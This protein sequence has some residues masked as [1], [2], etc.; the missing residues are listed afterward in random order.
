MDQKLSNKSNLIPI[1]KSD[2][3]DEQK[4]QEIWVVLAK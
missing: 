1:S 3:V 4:E 2:Q